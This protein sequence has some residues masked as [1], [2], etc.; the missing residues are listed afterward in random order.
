VELAP[1]RTGITR[2]GAA[3]RGRLG[4][5]VRALA[6]LAGVGWLAGGSCVVAACYE[7]CDPCF[8]ACKCHKV[9]QNP[10][11]GEPGLRIAA[12]DAR[13]L[14]DSGGRFVRVVRVAVGP[15]LEFVPDADPDRLPDFARRILDVNSDLFTSRRDPVWH[16]DAVQ[17]FP[18][19]SVLQ[20]ALVPERCA[21]PSS[22]SVSLLFDARGRLL[23]ADH[24]VDRA[25]D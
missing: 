21:A 25:P 2:L 7:E 15:S 5:A 6:P 4:R 19:C 22:N 11:A 20:F 17:S 13:V 24:V 14:P 23:E 1:D 3:A 9:C 16:L 8:Q 10:V 12:Y 18:E